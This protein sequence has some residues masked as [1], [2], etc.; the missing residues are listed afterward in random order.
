MDKATVRTTDDIKLGLKCCISEEEAECDICPYQKET[1]CFTDLKRD[2][3]G[4]INQHGK[5]VETALNK[6]TALCEDIKTNATRDICNICKHC[7]NEI[8]CDLECEKCKKQ[9][10]CNTCK[11]CDKWEW[12][13]E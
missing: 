6:F 8:D 5:G 12:R 1:F 3:L 9:C 13:G 4:L 2:A 11:D 10:I 7:E